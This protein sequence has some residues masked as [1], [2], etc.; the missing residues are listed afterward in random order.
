MIRPSTCIQAFSSPGEIRAVAVRDGRLLDVAIHRPGRPDGVGDRYLGRVIAR[1]P[2]LG[3]AF[4]ALA[5]AD[6]F[7][8]DSS[9]AAGLGAGDTL[10]VQVTRAAQ[11]GKGPRLAACP[12]Q[13]APDGAAPGALLSRGPGAVE[14]LAALHP[15]T[16]ILASSPGL[17]A[18]LGPA[19]RDRVSVTP[20]SAGAV[21]DEL[22]QLARPEAPLPGGMRAHFHPTP[23]LVAIDI[24]AGQVSAE[25]RAK[26]PAHLAA[27]RAALPEIA[28]QIR[29]RNLSG[30]ILLDLAGLSPSKR[31]ALAPDLA[32]CLADDPLRPRL[33]GFTRLGLAEIVRTRVHPPLHEL[34][35][36]PHAAGLAALRDMQRAAL[37]HPATAWSLRAAPDVVAAL[38]EDPVA[39]TDFACVTGRHVVLRSDPRLPSCRAAIQDCSGTDG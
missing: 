20:G 37:A 5:G 31:A 3:G 6:G 14:R 26:T 33:L 9:G 21:P 27:N 18:A 11:G 8:P 38:Q 13:P 24:D 19:L 23:A 35:H 39:L 10:V 36:G 22:D 4:V 1:V 17:A 25:R 2:A 15:R 7:L 30:A 28:R 16:P 34:L 12:D 32:A 29:L